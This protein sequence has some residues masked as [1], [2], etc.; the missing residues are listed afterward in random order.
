ML[1][2]KYSFEEIQDAL[3]V[4]SK[5]ILKGDGCFV[6]TSLVQGEDK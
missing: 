1:G 5:E 6:Q 4:C 2:G 3:S